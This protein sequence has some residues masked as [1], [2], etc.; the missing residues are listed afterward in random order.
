M[1]AIKGKQQV[2]MFDRNL[3]THTLEIFNP[4]VQLLREIFYT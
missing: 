1:R 2:M 3:P 4:H